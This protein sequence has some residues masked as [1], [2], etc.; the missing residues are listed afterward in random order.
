[1]KSIE[2]QEA[3]FKWAVDKNFNAPYG[4]LQGEYTNS[5][6]KK[7]KTV[8]F[9][10]ARTLDA[11]VEIYNEKFIILRTNAIHSKLFK[12]YEFLKKELETL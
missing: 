5:K 8:T 12:S 9:G 10:R 4:V 2:I 1:M 11:T 6:G 7:Y 3:I